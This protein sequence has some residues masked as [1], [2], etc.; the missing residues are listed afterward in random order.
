MK[1]TA[2][3]VALALLTFGPR[4]GTAD[5]PKLA[6]IIVV[7]QMRADY[8]DRFK[9]DWT[10]GLKRLVTEGAWFRRASYPYLLTVTCA[11][12]ATIAT[13]SFPNR[14][15][16]F[17]NQWWDRTAGRQVTCTED[18]AVAN[19]GYDGPAKEHN[20]AARLRVETF[21]D[22]LRTGR[23]SH[24][25]TLSIKPRSAIMLAGHGGDAVTW[26]SE[27]H[28]RWLTSAAFSKGP[29]PEVARFIGDHP[30][31]EDFGKS[32]TPLFPLER[33]R[34]SD[35]G[36]GERAVPGWTPTF[37]H[38][39][40]GT[41]GKQDETFRV[42]WETS[43]FADAYFANM[44]ATLAEDLRLGKHDGTDV[45]G[46]SFSS[47]D[48]VG[49]KFGPRS[50]ELQ[51]QLARLDLTLGA[52]L[53]RLDAA[54]GRGR[55]VV[56]LTA[57]H[58]VTAV[59]EQL[60]AEHVDG[61]RI[62]A[63]KIVQTVEAALQ[64]Q[65]G[66]GPHVAKLDRRDLNV[67]FAAGAYDRLRASPPLMDRVLRTIAAAPGVQQVFRAEEL[68]DAVRSTDAWRRA[69]AL[70][71]VEGRSGDIIIAPRPGWIGADEAAS[72]G[73]ASPDDQR[74]PILFM[75]HGIKAGRYDQPVTPA[76]IAPTLAAIC[77]I[78]MPQ[79]EGR[80]LRG[81]LK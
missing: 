35:A 28:D 36:V 17:S 70:S 47:L 81:A 32:W 48:L 75:G 44:A 3:V 66:A 14:H 46:I 50:V 61:G 34:G 9:G 57:D 15:G 62:D 2:L 49:H 6:V 52:L 53:D 13:G 40:K 68:R 72:H 74:V 54:V 69:A 31:A 27:A 56:A 65:L 12:H 63:A 19:I 24:V 80:V 16:I 43:P 5:P 25:A 1:R 29:V 38:V 59:P 11:G 41:A 8:I 22:R 7:D 55:Y 21:A 60:T 39:L 64:P 45:L 33:Y 67:Y 26:I 76:D 42:Q 23:G 37:P 58:G 20:S 71:Y 78:T 18:E 79:A 4:A 77:G 51:D 10:A 30:V 73:T